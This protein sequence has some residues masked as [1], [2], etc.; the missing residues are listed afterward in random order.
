[1]KLMKLMT[2][3]KPI[4]PKHFWTERFMHENK[5]KL[6]LQITVLPSDLKNYLRKL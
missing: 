2:T 3:T 5:K 1:M 6:K 4:I